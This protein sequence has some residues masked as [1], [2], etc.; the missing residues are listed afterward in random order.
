MNL[1]K[2]LLTVVSSIGHI[3][4]EGDKIKEDANKGHFNPG[5]LGLLYHFRGL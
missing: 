1:K 4:D 5:K 3:F 2:T